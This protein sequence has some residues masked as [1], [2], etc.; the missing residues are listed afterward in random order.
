MRMVD[1]RACRHRPVQV[2]QSAAGTTALADRDPITNVQPG[3]ASDRFHFG[4][5]TSMSREFNRHVEKQFAQ[6]MK[7]FDLEP[8]RASGPIAWPGERCFRTRGD[9]TVCWIC[10][11]PSYKGLDEFNVELAWSHRG[12]YPASCT[13]RP[14]IRATP[15]DCFAELA[16]GFLRLGTLA[17]P[18]RGSW[19]ATAMHERLAGPDP[20]E[21]KAI[22]SALVDDAVRTIEGVGLP[23]AAQAVAARAAFLANAG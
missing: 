6:R 1:R 11:F 22:V 21:V 18:P 12:E 17:V 20:E 10:V 19:A 2:R 3:K 7:R 13:S 23:L 16:E 9:D 4:T 14:T 5:H 8:T 15:P